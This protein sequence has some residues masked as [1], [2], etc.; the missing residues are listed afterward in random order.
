[1]NCGGK[2]E[3]NF[4]QTKFLTRVGAAPNLYILCL[5]VNVSKIVLSN[6]RFPE[7]RRII[8]KNIISI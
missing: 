1:M 7:D 6:A 2:G 4:R 8:S 5:W 3:A